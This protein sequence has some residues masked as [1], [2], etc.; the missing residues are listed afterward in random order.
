[1]TEVSN[2]QGASSVPIQTVWDKYFRMDESAQKNT[3]TG[4][5]HFNSLEE[6]KACF[7]QMDTDNI[8]M[9]DG[10]NVI[11]TTN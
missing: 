5:A 8:V 7:A 6:V 3:Q 2:Q 1:M 9:V 10:D 11:Q 4:N